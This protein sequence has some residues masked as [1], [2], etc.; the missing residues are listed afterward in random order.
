MYAEN[1]PM[2]KKALAEVTSWGSGKLGHSAR[3]D[4]ERHM[5]DPRHPRNLA[6]I[7]GEK[8]GVPF[9]GSCS[10]AISDQIVG[11]PVRTL[12]VSSRIVDRR[13]CQDHP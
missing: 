13:V 1:A 4:D 10:Q 3:Q 2:P 6:S 8:V 11:V 5:R 9:V 7:R 12:Q